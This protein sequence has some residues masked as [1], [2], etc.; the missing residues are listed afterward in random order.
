MTT[1]R[2][3]FITDSAGKKLV[4]LTDAEF[5]HLME[6]IE[7]LEDVRLYDEVKKSDDGTRIPMEDVFKK[8]DKKGSNS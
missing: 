3:Q 6:E 2:P 1:I 4:V 8:I 7:N 5:N